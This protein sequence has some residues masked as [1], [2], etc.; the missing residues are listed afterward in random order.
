MQAILDNEEAISHAQVMA[1]IKSFYPDATS[2]ELQSIDAQDVAFR[3]DSGE[4]VTWVEAAVFYGEQK[5]R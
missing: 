2:D 1:L 3:M 4:P 5:K